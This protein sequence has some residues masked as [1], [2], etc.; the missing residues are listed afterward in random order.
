MGF[1]RIK[2][3]RTSKVGRILLPADRQQASLFPESEG[4]EGKTERKEKEKKKAR[5]KEVRKTKGQRKRKE[6]RKAG[7]KD[8][9]AR[10][11]L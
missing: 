11:F 7:E 8:F 2:T 6:E 4:K 9:T 3:N 1:Y 5:T 10:E